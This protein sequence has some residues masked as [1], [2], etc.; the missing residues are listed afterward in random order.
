MAQRPRSAR[1]NGRSRAVFVDDIEEHEF[2]DAAR[3]R[4]SGHAFVSEVTSNRKVPRPE[5]DNFDGD[6]LVKPYIEAEDHR[7]AD[8][9]SRPTTGRGWPRRQRAAPVAC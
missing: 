8:G 3:R 7:I 5:L 2:L 6:L 4:V 9:S 1:R